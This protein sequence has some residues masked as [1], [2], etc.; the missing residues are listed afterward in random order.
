M[1]DSV[2]AV[3]RLE[4]DLEAASSKY[5]FLQQLRA[6]VADLCDMLQVRHHLKYPLLL[7]TKPYP[8]SIK[9]HLPAAAACPRGR[10]LRYAAGSG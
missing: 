4:G 3:A 9:M 1:Q 8:A 2:A 6:F 5:T 10:P 7:I